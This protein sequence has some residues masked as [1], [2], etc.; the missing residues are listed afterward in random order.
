VHMKGEGGQCR[1]DRQH[2]TFR[3]H[4]GLWVAE[5]HLYGQTKPPLSYCHEA[6]MGK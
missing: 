4:W 6:Q 5:N 2:E 1:A 3:S